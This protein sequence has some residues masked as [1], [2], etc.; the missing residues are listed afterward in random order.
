VAK[1][2]DTLSSSERNQNN[3]NVSEEVSY[4]SFSFCKMY[5]L[6]FFFSSLL[7]AILAYSFES[8][9]ASIAM[10]VC[11]FMCER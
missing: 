3:V 11:V 9:I 1:I 5:R 10:C 4:R 7:K 2:G 8:M 6:F